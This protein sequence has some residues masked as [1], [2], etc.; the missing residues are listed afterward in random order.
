MS[1]FSA[2]WLALREAADRRARAPSLLA[3]LENAHA[4]RS[5][6]VIADIG[7]GTGS[8]IR[9][10][11]HLLP[12]QQTWR[13]YDYDEA[14]LVAARASLA[15]WADKAGETAE[16]LTLHRRERSIRATFH[17]LDLMAGLARVFEPPPDLVT[18][19]AFFDLVSKDWIDAFVRQA[20]MARSAVYAAINYNGEEEWQ[21]PHPIDAAVL[22][23][24][25][26]HQ[27]TDKGFGPAAGPDAVRHLAGALE[28]AGYDVLTADSPWL[29]G[30][31]DEKL[32][33]AIAAGSAG[34][35]SE[36]GLVPAAD[37]AA[38]REARI[39]A[40][41]CRIGHTDVLAFPPASA[42]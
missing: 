15:A 33:E 40:A 12:P 31:G 29:L 18:A 10:I 9:A 3:R 1:G 19:S 42:A 30:A 22:A 5:A 16:G 38:W 14:L 7:C 20:A 8:T 26:A 4:A 25:H 36:T 24:F 21:P 39:R 13:L 41:T 17:R 6:I 34:A 37:V 11:A 32:I 23:A 2:D 28:A 35:T 27:R